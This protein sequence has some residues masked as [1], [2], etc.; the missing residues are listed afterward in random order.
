MPRTFALL[1]R[2]AAAAPARD[3]YIM[4]ESHEGA[5]MMFIVMMMPMG[6]STDQRTHY[7]R[8]RACSQDGAL[9]TADA[10]YGSA[11]PAA[12]LA[13]PARLP[14]HSRVAVAI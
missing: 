5:S 8:R 4:N 3:I 2:D 1:K 14:A 13:I 12:A 7:R 6:I 9:L 11:R 10:V